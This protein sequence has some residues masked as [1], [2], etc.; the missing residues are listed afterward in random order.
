[1][2]CISKPLKHSSPA[3]SWTFL[4]S[5]NENLI[6]LQALR[7]YLLSF[8]V[9]LSLTFMREQRNK[10]TRQIICFVCFLKACAITHPQCFVIVRAIDTNRCEERC[11]CLM[12][13]KKNLNDSIRTNNKH[14][15]RDTDSFTGLTTFVFFSTWRMEEYLAKLISLK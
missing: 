15:C 4:N 13:D 10:K 14:C 5:L 12:P 8:V 6:T 3:A 7:C 9:F 2:H 1:M 11:P